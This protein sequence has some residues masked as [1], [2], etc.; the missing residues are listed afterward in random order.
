MTGKAAI[1]GTAL[2]LVLGASACGG[3]GCSTSE[4]A[5]TQGGGGGGA[6]ASG[7]LEGETARALRSR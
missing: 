5:T 2:A 4:G 3:G 1:L 7:T 6:S